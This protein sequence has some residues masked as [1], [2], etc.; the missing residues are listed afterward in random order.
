MKLISSKKAF[1]NAIENGYLSSKKN[2]KN[3]AGKYMYMYSIEN[4]DYFKN[5]ITRKYLT[6]INK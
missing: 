1:L 6:F 5:I 2:T 4:K 3:Y